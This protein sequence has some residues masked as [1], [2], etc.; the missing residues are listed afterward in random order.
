MFAN[1]WKEKRI[2]HMQIKSTYK[3][4]DVALP[5]LAKLAIEARGGLERW[6]RFKTLSAHLIQGGVFWA[7]KGKA[8]V[9]DDVTV[10]VDLRYEKVSHW[11]F[12]SPDRR[13]RFEPQRAAFENATGQAL[14]ELLK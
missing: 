4:G 13:S 12:G 9:L 1:G 8:G 2:E 7:V 5:E 3:A 6:N 10:T 11:P 14:E